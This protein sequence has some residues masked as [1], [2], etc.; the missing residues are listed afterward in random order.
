M[1]NVLDVAP[2]KYLC[3]EPEYSCFN[4]LCIIYCSSEAHYIHTNAL[5]YGGRWIG[6]LIRNKPYISIN[7]YEDVYRSG[8]FRASI[9]VSDMGCKAFL[10]G[11]DILKESIVSAHPPLNNPVA[12]IDN[13]DNRVIGVAEPYHDVY[14]NIYDLGLFIRI[15]K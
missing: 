3:K 13:S 4:E 8:V 12:V 2:D 6:V 9:V 5:V 11:R 10:Y 7:I 1:R 15:M 14:K